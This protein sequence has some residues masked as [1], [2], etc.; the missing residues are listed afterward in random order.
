MTYVYVCVCMCVYVRV[1]VCMCVYEREREG[2]RGNVAK[3]KPL[4]WVLCLY[5]ASSGSLKKTGYNPIERQKF[6]IV[7]KLTHLFL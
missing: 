1:Y 5:L 2:G 6:F 7:R 4:N 3:E